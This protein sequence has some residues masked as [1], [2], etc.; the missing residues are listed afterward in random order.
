MAK[1][2]TGG[3]PSWIEEKPLIPTHRARPASKWQKSYGMFITGQSYIDQ[4]TLLAEEMECKWG[5]GRLRLVVRQ[6]LRDKFDRQRYL[7]N[8]AMTFGELEDVRVQS[9]RMAKAWK[10]LDKAADA[11]GAV[12]KSPDVWDVV[13]EH[14][15]VYAIARNNDEAKAYAALKRPARIFSVEEICRILDAQTFLDAVKDHFQEAEI[16]DYRVRAVGDVLD[17]VFDTAG[18]LDDPLPF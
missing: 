14:G 5:A 2:K 7:F 11:S 13:S 6:E 16:V 15:N 3:K 9:E 12:P 10:A 18:D 8:Q 1:G 17:D 4:V